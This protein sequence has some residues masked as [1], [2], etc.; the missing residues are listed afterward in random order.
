M[1]SKCEYEAHM[2]MESFNQDTHTHIQCTYIVQSTYIIHVLNIDHYNDEGF[3]DDLKNDDE[4]N[5]RV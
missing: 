2:G 5:W 4:S 1:L 3:D